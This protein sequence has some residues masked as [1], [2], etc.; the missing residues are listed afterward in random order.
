MGLEAALDNVSTIIAL[1]NF[2]DDTT[3]HADMVIPIQTELERFE[4]VEPGTSVGVPVLGVAEPV[5]DP[6]GV[7][8][9]P[10]DVVIQIAQ[11][12]GGSVAASFD[13]SDAE[14]LIE[15]L[16]QEKQSE[17]PGGEDLSQAAFFDAA[18]DR[19]GV[20]GTSEPTAVPPGPSG[21]AP[22]ITESRFEGSAT[23]YPYILMLSLIHI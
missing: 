17:L 1:S 19:G 7:G 22:D 4:L 20:F 21:A 10:A 12:L 11:G 14:E 3:L 13:W 9:H 15:S 5:I 16:L 18:I 8:P 2:R 6:M 23:D